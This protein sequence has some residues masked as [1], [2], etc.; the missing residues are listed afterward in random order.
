MRVESLDHIH[1]Y[2]ADPVASAAFYVRHFAAVEAVR[3]ERPDGP[4]SVVISLGG[5]IVILAS[6]PG[7]ISPAAPPSFGDGAYAHGFGVAHFGLRVDDVHAAVRELK[8]ADVRVLADPVE[9]PDLTYAYVAAPDGVV[10]ELTQ[11]PTPA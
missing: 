4:P 5:R 10:L 3:N 7:D 2:S 9:E 11:Y 8:Q 6:F 1:I